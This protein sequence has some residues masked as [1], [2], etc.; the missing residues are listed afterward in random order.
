MH[1]IEI[2]LLGLAAYL[3]IGIIFAGAFMTKGIRTVDNIA[4]SSSL[5]FKVVILPGVVMLWPIL[6][7]KW[8]RP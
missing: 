2:I 3:L 8:I 4:S 6:L 1:F 7:K 5:G